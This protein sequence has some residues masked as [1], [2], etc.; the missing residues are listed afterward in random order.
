M[1][2][3]PDKY[4]IDLTSTQNLLPVNTRQLK[5]L[6]TLTLQEEQ[7][8]SAAIDVVIVDDP[9]IHRVNLEHLEHDYPT[10]VISFLYETSEPQ[11]GQSSRALLRG[12][13][14]HLE[15]ELIVSAETA[16]REAGNFGWDPEKELS[17]YLV[18]GLLH[19]CGYDDLTPE[20]QRVMRERERSILK[21][22]GFTPH[23]TD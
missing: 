17:L 21:I 6:L 22:L 2:P 4:R 9:T 5:H 3:S 15:G 1:S 19:L 20:E 11:P 16:L 8:E 18:H 10:D 14:L 23:Y 12:Q 13:G 7:V